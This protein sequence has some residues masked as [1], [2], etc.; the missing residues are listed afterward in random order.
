M[1]GESCV[2]TNRM[3]SYILGNDWLNSMG[4]L[5]E[6]DYVFMVNGWLMNTVE[7]LTKYK[8]IFLEMIC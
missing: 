4:V 5:M 7:V 1:I 3:A 8:G 2:S 6:W